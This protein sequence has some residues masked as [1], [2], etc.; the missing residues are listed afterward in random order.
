MNQ[1]KITALVLVLALLIVGSFSVFTVSE[2]QKAIMFRLG[3]IVK[4]NFTPGLHFKVPFVNNVRTFEAR[5]MT[6]DIET[7]RYL[8]SEKKNLLVDAFVKWR[9]NNVARFY[10]SVSGDESQGA[11]RLSQ[12]IKDSLRSEFGKRTIQEVISG[13]RSQIMDNVTSFANEQA[14]EFG[15]AVV[16]VRLK[17]I[18]LPPDVSDSVYRRMEAERS[19]V[20]RE[21]RSQGAEAAERIRADADRRRTEILADAYRE[22]QQVRGAGDAQAADIYAKAYDKNKEFYAFYRSLESYRKTF[23]NKSDMVVVDP[24]S[25]FFKYF[26]HSEPIRK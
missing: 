12:I 5:L 22:S 26:K 6:L 13:E 1:T 14:K 15:I 16:D 19:R 2:T 4:T 21:F 7:E 25:E 17:R 24:S 23:N 9:I 18:D 10:R 8:T 3:E 11:L 20:A